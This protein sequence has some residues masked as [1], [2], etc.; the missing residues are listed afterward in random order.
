[1]NALDLWLKTI[2]QMYDPECMTALQCKSIAGDLQEKV[3]LIALQYTDKLREII[4]QSRL[5]EREVINLHK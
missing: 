4:G 1:M 2:R 3:N 5:I